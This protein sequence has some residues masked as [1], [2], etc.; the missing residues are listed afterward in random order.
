MRRFHSHKAAETDYLDAVVIPD[1][2]FLHGKTAFLFELENAN[3][4]RRFQN[5]IR[6]YEEMLLK[7][8][9]QRFFPIFR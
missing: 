6:N 8:D 5:K 9:A 7:K 3:S 2:A 1:L 4:Y